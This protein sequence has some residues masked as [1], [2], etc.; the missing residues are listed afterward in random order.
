M[1]STLV[2]NYSSI[3]T[4]LLCWGLRVL[5]F[6]RHL[7][8]NIFS[9]HGNMIK[10]CRLYILPSGTIQSSLTVIANYWRTKPLYQ[11]LCPCKKGSEQAGYLCKLPCNLIINHN[12]S[13]V[14]AHEIYPHLWQYRVNLFVINKWSVF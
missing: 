7:L 1:V 10:R 2:G 9:K 13:D 12:R 4:E 14:E 8:F 5:G 3:S 6:P 11:V